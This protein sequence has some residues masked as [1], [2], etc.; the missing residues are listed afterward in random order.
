MKPLAQPLY[1]RNTIVDLFFKLASIKMTRH[2][3]T[4]IQET[5]QTP[6]IDT[7][8]VMIREEE[9]LDWMTPYKNFLIQGM[10]PSDENETWRLK[11]KANY[12][13]VLDGELLKK[14]L[15]T[16]L[17]KCL[18]IQ[19]ANYVMRGLHEGIFDLHT[20]GRSLATKVVRVGYY[21]PTFRANTLD[22]TKR[23]R[24]CHEFASIPCTPP[25]NLHSLSSSWPFAM[26]GMNILGPLLKAPRTVKYLLM[27]IDYFT[28]GIEARP[29]WEITTN[30]VE[31]F[32]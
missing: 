28:K 20:G 26:W 2:L 15:T 32:T 5:L 27:A 31:K 3:K 19:L 10:L 29:L 8:E 18:N 21:W 22:F 12:N 9:E 16:P 25:D 7:E 4:I 6:T 24:W 17:L 23:C 30:K 13:I 14:G 11:W 1:K